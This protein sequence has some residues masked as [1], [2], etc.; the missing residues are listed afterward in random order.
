MV[1]DYTRMHER[2]TAP[3][4]ATGVRRDYVLTPEEFAAL[5]GHSP[6]VCGYEDLERPAGGWHTATGPAQNHPLAHRL[7]RCPVGNPAV[8]PTE[9][10]VWAKVAERVGVHMLTIHWA[11]THYPE[12]TAVPR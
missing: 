3:L 6:E 4:V 7:H 9:V 10:S 1:P 2:P 11:D 8:F 5:P 12:F